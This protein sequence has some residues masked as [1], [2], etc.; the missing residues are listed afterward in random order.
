MTDSFTLQIAFLD[1]LFPPSGANGRGQSPR[2]A[3]PPAHCAL[4][5]EPLIEIEFGKHYAMCCDNW[6]CHIYRQ[7]QGCRAKEHDEYAQDAL[8]I[9]MERLRI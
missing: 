7:P 6:H 9:F 5:G 2:L 3:S 4:C 8:G 1:S